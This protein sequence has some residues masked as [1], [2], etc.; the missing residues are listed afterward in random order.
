MLSTSDPSRLRAFVATPG[1]A[2]FLTGRFL[3][4]MGIWSERIAI[5]WLVW[6]RT[7]STAILG[8]AAFLKLGP[9][10]VLGP[11]GGV[12]A[13]RM[14]S[15]GLLRASY[16]LNAFLA[17][18][19]AVFAFTLPLWSVLSLTAALGCVQ[20]IAAAPIKSVVPQIV[21]REDLAVAFP[22]S[23]ATFNLAAFVGPA[24]AGIAIAT[25]GLWAAF[26]VSVLG[27][28]IFC[29]VLARWSATDRRAERAGTHWLREIVDAAAFVCRDRQFS[30]IMALHVAAA[31][32]LRPF[33]DLLPA[34]V[35]R[36]GSGGPAMLGF[37]TSAFGL[38]A[39]VG[40]I[41]M[42]AA[43]IEVALAR[44]LLW[45]TAIAIICLLVIALGSATLTFLAMVT[46]FG[47]AMMVRGT[48]TLTLVQLAAPQEMRGRISG[49]YSTI[50]RGGAAIGA[51]LIGLAAI[52]V[53]LPAAT[54]GAAILCALALALC[55][56]HLHGP[57]NGATT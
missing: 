3:A 21:R 49:L 13:D 40:A 47:A 20:A 14:G 1:I 6:E 29:L 57:N 45:G 54:A 37:A 17:L 23:S 46:G 43:A 8:L 48:A 11:I 5:G 44:R 39:V 16:G 30:A 51:A 9:A 41:W 53:G 31:F 2:A 25:L 27:A 52:P 19:L 50:I 26:S 42:A 10:I 22:L 38:G 4:A 12:M 32:C 35:A 56:P 36:L 33:I 55:W 24:V 15:V 34:H 7:G 28:T 18:L